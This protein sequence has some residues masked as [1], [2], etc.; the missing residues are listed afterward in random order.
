MF[1][2]LRISTSVNPPS[3]FLSPTNWPLLPTQPPF[4]PNPL[5]T[6]FHLCV[7]VPLLI[8]SPPLSP[9]PLPTFP[10]PARRSPAPKEPAPARNSRS[11]ELKESRRCEYIMQVVKS[12]PK[13]GNKNKRKIQHGLQHKSFVLKH[14]QL[15][16]PGL[17]KGPHAGP[18][19]SEPHG[20]EQPECRSPGGSIKLN[21]CSELHIH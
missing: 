1:M 13:P 14:D 4:T 7:D 17:A 5:P 3:P 18:L 8:V 11:Q 20:G 12:T 15:L 16:S 10:P 21:T 9:Q 6:P 19:P 2:F